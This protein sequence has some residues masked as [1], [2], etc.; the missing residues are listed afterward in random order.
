MADFVLSARNVRAGEFGSEPGPVKY[1]VVPDGESPQPG[2]AIG[3]AEWFKAVRAAAED[4]NDVR[5]GNVTFFVHGY[6]NTPDSVISRHRQIRTGISPHGYVGTLVSFDWPSGS[7]PLAYIEDRVDA[8]KTALHLVDGGIKPFVAMLEPDCRISLHVLAHSMGAYVVREAFDDADD[9]RVTAAANWTCGQLVFVAADL[10]SNSLETDDAAGA[11]LYLHCLRFTNYWSR[12]DRALG[13]SGAKR[14]G[15]APRAGRV[16][17]PE[18]V[19]GKAVSVDATEFYQ[20]HYP[21]DGLDISQSHS[22]YFDDA[23][24]S[25]DLADTLMNV[26]RGA[27]ATR[28]FIADGRFELRAV[29]GG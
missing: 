6:N 22:W 26:D 21:Q 2:H 15:I 28:T 24:F 13:V 1:L 11:S 25:R 4:P 3:K 10:S 14:V 20:G 8:K 12:A 19:P 7:E 27:M 5:Q 9:R 16:G 29:S 17:L 18:R 23:T